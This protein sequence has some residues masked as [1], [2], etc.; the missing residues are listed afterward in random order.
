[1][2]KTIF[3]FLSIFVL[4]VTLADAQTKKKIANESKNVSTLTA[5]K[6]R[7]FLYTRTLKEITDLLQ[8]R[9]AEEWTF[10]RDNLIE[11]DIIETQM[12]GKQTVIVAQIRTGNSPNSITKDFQDNILDATLIEGRIRLTFENVANEFTLLK[13]ENLTV[14]YTKIA[15]NIKIVE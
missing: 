6:I 11:L 3:I 4:S 13:I 7:P 14:K 10:S 9:P 8:D 2:K 15:P 12:Q 1:M 5:Q